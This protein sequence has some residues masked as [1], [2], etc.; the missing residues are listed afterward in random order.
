MNLILRHLVMSQTRMGYTHACILT[1]ETRMKKEHFISSS[2]KEILTIQS[3]VSHQVT[4]L[5][6]E[7]MKLS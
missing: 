5:R 1:D 4:A 3:L 7:E 6:N 2:N